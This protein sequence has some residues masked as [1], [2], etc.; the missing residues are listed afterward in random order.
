[1]HH[2]EGSTS[3]IFI[4][5]LFSLFALEESAWIHCWVGEDTHCFRKHPLHHVFPYDSLLF[6]LLCS[7]DEAWGRELEKAILEAC[8]LY[9]E[10]MKSC[11]ANSESVIEKIFEDRLS[12]S[13]HSFQWSDQLTNSY[14]VWACDCLDDESDAISQILIQSTQISELLFAVALAFRSFEEVSWNLEVLVHDLLSDRWR[15]FRSGQSQ[16]HDDGPHWWKCSDQSP[17]KFEPFNDE[18]FTFQSWLGPVKICLSFVKLREFILISFLSK[19]RG[20]SSECDYPCWWDPATLC[21]RIS[22]WGYLMPKRDCITKRGRRSGRRTVFMDNL[23]FKIMVTN[24][25]S[26]AESFSCADNISVPSDTFYGLKLCKL[27]S[28]YLVLENLAFWHIFRPRKSSRPCIHIYLVSQ[29]LLFHTFHK[30]W[31]W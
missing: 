29:R 30:A 3:A 8:Q 26:F 31:S 19:F 1:M 13:I 2:L 5:S 24:S 22:K 17:A 20:A 18:I 4:L 10:Q 23:N 27:I 12:E 25:I 9:R 15:S 7:Q 11:T 21:T 14:R 28:W 16:N 6:R